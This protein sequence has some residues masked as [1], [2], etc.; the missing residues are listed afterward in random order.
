MQ[1]ENQNLTTIPGNAKRIEWKPICQ[2]VGNEDTEASSQRQLAYTFFWFSPL[3]N[4]KDRQGCAA[5]AKT[6]QGNAND[7]EGKMIELRH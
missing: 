5:S 3:E 2:Q 1:D 6:E 7:H 4:G